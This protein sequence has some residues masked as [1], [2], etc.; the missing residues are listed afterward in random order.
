MPHGHVLLGY[1]SEGRCP[2]LG[3]HGCSIYEHRPRTCRTYDC[4][5]FPAAGVEVTEVVQVAIGRR[6][7]RW[8]FEHPT[9]TDR[10][11]HDAVR[12]AAAADDSST[13]ATERAVR[14]V[15]SVVYES[16]S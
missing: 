8:R 5:I 9:E 7:R 11:E 6:A 14:A 10:R 12:A 4:R 3:D 15:R 2:M 13:S 1:D 16:P